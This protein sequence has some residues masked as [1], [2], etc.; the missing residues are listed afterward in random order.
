[1]AE[2]KDDSE[3]TEEPTGKRLSDARDKG[4]LPMSRELALWST[5]TMTLVVV[6]SLA[7]TIAA[8][9]RDGLVGLLAQAGQRPMDAGNVGAILTDLA[10]LTV[11]AVGVPMALLA[12]AGIA[13]TLMQTGG[14]VSTSALAPRFE[15]LNPMAGF[16]RLFSASA[17]VEFAKSVAKMAIVGVVIYQALRPMLDQMEHF[18]GLG[19]GRVMAETHEL[20][21]DMLVGVVVVLTVI[22]VADFFYQRW[23]FY[24]DLRMSKQ[25]VKDEH[26]QMEGDPVVKGRIRSLRMQRARRR[27]M[28]NVPKAD[29][30]VTNPTHF[31]CALKY[32]PGSMQ[33]PI[34]LAKGAD[35]VAFRIRELAKEHGVPVVENPPLARA[36]YAAVEI[37]QEVPPEHY[38]AMAEVISY[39]FR[40]KRRPIEA[41]R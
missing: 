39:V 28:A 5:L 8:D 31:A 32:D 4:Q 21:V 33:A 34:L 36:L 12:A 25:E 16:K 9:T 18:A 26:K 40:L 41:R 2:D 17:L 30:V 23:K 24:K 7:P 27:M 19:M 11:K 13:A 37:D 1:M 14:M 6:T 20:I 38:K 22:M 35:L 10:W 15:K 29:V 3:K